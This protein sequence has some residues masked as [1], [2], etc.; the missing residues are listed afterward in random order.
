MFAQLAEQLRKEGELEEA[1]GVARAGLERHPNYPSARLTL[2]RALLD[3]GDPAAAQIELAAAVKGAPDNILAS[4][5]L[6]EALETL[7][8]LGAALLQAG[9]AQEAEQV[10][11]KSLRILPKNG[12][13]LYG[14]MEAQK[15]QGKKKAA[16]ATEKRFRKAWAGDPKAMNLKRL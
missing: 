3:S 6:G 10:F 8:D 16:K 14:L 7:G 12:W 13:A 1:I 9:K 15:A 4:R 2:G 11:Q 5:L